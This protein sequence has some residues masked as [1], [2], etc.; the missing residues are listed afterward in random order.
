MVNRVWIGALLSLLFWCLPTQAAEPVQEFLEGLRDRG[1]YDIAI[2]YLDQL[3]QR[4][5][6]SPEQR[7]LLPFERAQTLKTGA[8]LLNSAEAQRQQLDAARAAYQQFSKASPNHALAA[9]ANTSQ[10]QILVKKARIEIHEAD[11]PVNASLRIT[12]QQAAR[13]LLKQATQVFQTAGDAYKKELDKFPSFI[14]EAEASRV[15]ARRAAEDPYLEVRLELAQCAYWEAHT[16]DPD[17]SEKTTA[18]QTA[19]TAFE[20]IFNSYRLQ[21]VGKYGRLW[22]GKCYEEQNQITQALGIFEDLLLI[23]PNSPA[24]TALYDLTLR[25]KLICLNNPA[26][27]DYPLVVTLAEEWIKDARGRERTEVGLGI[28]WELCRAQESLGT[29]RNITESARN[30]ALNQALNRGRILNRT[31]GEFKAPAGALVQRVLLALNRDAND[32]T[33]FDAAYGL[34]GKLRDELRTLSQQV[35]SAQ[36]A[37][38]ADEVKTRQAALQTAS[39]EMVRVCDLALKLTKPTTDARL[40]DNA[41]LLLAYGYLIDNRSMEAAIVAEHL[42]KRS[43]TNNPDT[44]K[45]AAIVT[46]TALEKNYQAAKGQD[47][48]YESNSLRDMAIRIEQSQPNT[49]Q[50]NLARETIAKVYR[51][52]GQLDEAA[53]WWNKIPAGSP[54]YASSQLMA[55]QAFWG[56]VGQKSALPDGE[57]P[58]PEKL[59]EWQVLA[60]KHLEAGITE[61]AKGLPADAAPPD[62]LILAKMTLSQIR[63]RQGYYVTRDGVTGALELLTRDPHSVMTA[64]DVPE[65]QPRPKI[66]GHPKS[67]QMASFAYQQLLKGYIGIKDLNSARDARLQLEAIAAGDSSDAEALTQVFIEFGKELEN[68]LKQLR[69]EGDTVR[70]D[71]VREGFES[72]LNDLFQREDGQ[73]F[74][75]LFWI[76]ETFNSLAEGSTDSRAK[77]EGFLAKASE[78]YGKIVDRT[79]A[80][81]KFT[82]LANLAAI[83]VRLVHCR[84][85][86]GSFDEAEKVLQLLLKDPASKDSPSVQMAGAELYQAWAENGGPTAAEKYQIAIAGQR[87][88]VPM[89][90]WA[91]TAQ[92]MQRANRSRKDPKLEALEYESRYHLA[93]CQLALWRLQTDAVAKK[94]TIEQARFG[95]EAFARLSNAFPPEEFDRF[96][97]LYR[98]ILK[99]QGDPLTDLPVGV[100]GKAATDPLAGIAVNGAGTN[101]DGAVRATT[102]L[103]ATP[104]EAAPAAGG[105]SK[106]NV[107]MIVLLTLIGLVAIVGI[108]RVAMKPK[109]RYAGRR[110]VRSSPVKSEAPLFPVNPNPSDDAPAASE[111]PPAPRPAKAKPTRLP[112]KPSAGS[113]Q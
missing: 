31:S 19:A 49:D 88:P 110:A 108:L 71:E 23:E 57:R 18:L 54:N 69:A 29:D 82:S 27:K 40:V 43:G 104:A 47:R 5:S 109:D 87:E 51:D 105:G 41:T 17:S 39:S 38:N 91:M 107:V 68:E 60:V 50:A 78:A 59:Q 85:S 79:V 67:R 70:L 2:Q 93:R 36:K 16:Y 103:P 90:G 37:G 61:R 20:E 26:K 89:W 28:Q 25:F 95:L 1:Y 76:A 86:Q 80:D 62:D 12:H 15:A 101:G 72:F 46:I 65:G 45:Q 7:E 94:K 56:Q 53:V 52:Q 98:S 9:K 35:Q 33:D 63:N 10:G 4:P 13:D 58:A 64:I 55:G 97:T 92:R 111:I 96:N 32:P 102:P 66:V 75:S 14:P 73:N 113:D 11:D 44:A 8:L 99:E 106:T 77:A 24:T 112:G 34:A 22:W 84:Q 74:S 6:L 30:Q 48:E 42:M 81:P 100:G 21:I 83:K 3:E